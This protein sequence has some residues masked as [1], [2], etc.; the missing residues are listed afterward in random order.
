MMIRSAGDAIDVAARAVDAKRASKANSVVAEWLDVEPHTVSGW[1]VR[2]IS[3][4][5]AVHFFAELVEKRGHTLSP[6]VFGLKSWDMVLM[7]DAR[8]RK[9]RRVA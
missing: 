5:F 2:G 9:L 8:G 4:N 6:Q 1:R 7:P 3:R